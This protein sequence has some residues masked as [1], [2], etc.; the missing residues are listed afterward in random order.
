M[1]C[2]TRARKAAA[3]PVSSFRMTSC[4]PPAS[5]VLLA[6]LGP[7]FHE[8]CPKIFWDYGSPSLVHRL[9]LLSSTTM[10]S[11]GNTPF[12]LIVDVHHRSPLGANGEAVFI[13]ASDAGR[14]AER[15]ERVRGQA[16]GGYIS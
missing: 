1:N 2:A 3:L 6:L 15:G 8:V 12:R 14:A 10:P 7:A 5:V 16:G 13:A 4:P 11:Q 9:P